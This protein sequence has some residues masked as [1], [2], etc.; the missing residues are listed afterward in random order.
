MIVSGRASQ[1]LATALAAATDL[2]LAPTTYEQFPDGE[3]LVTVDFTGDH[4]VIIASTTTADRHIELL[5][6]QDAVRETGATVTTVIPY[7]GYARQD[8]V[9]EPGQPVSARA[10]ARAISTGTDRVLVVNPHQPTVCEYFDGPAVPVDAAGRLADPLPRNLTDPVFLG[11]DEG[12]IQ[13]AESVKNAYDAGTTDYFTKTRLSGTDVQ[14][15]P[16]DTDV[17][18]RDVVVVDDIIST[19]GT[20]CEAVSVLH[21]RGADRVYAAAVHPV[22]AGNALVRLFRAGVEEVYGTDTLER[23]IPTATVAPVIAEHL[24]QP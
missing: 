21:D 18:G 9:F 15:A 2:P 17:G 22:L 8:T 6:L 23:A 13:I 12:A 7:M 24:K 14:I 5:Q 19:G 3:H 20:I 16:S 1:R 11:P 10:V 4:A